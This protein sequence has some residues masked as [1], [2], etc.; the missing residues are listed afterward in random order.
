MDAGSRTG[1]K[2]GDQLV[3]SLEHQ[4]LAVRDLR[5]TDVGRV[6]FQDDGVAQI[7]RQ[8]RQLLHILGIERDGH[9]YAGRFRRGVLSPFVENP[10]HRLRIRHDEAKRAAQLL[11]VPRDELA[12]LV[13]ES[14][15]RARRAQRR[16][17][18]IEDVKPRPG[19]I[20]HRGHA[21]AKTESRERAEQSVGHQVQRRNA[22]PGETSEE[23]EVVRGTDAQDD[24]DG[25]P[26]REPPQPRVQP[27]SIALSH[28]T[29]A[30]DWWRSHTS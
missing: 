28:P 27:R 2:S 20:F 17:D 29:R 1:R 10:A 8:Q 18:T 21:H 14:E 24:R 23:A 7:R 11:R 30:A 4:H 9:S 26:G 5:A 22:T 3:G 6:R 16:P 12:M 25:L 19:I 13:R 15:Q